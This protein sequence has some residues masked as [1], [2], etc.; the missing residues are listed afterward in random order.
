ME[1]VNM[2]EYARCTLCPRLCG[3]RR[4]EGVYGACHAGAAPRV[5]H[6]RLH[7]WEEPCLSG[8]RGSGTVF[9]SGCPLSCVYCQNH[10]ISR[11]YIGA[12]YSVDELA[13]LFLSLESQGAHNVNLVTATHYLPHVLL[14]IEGARE[15]G[16]SVPVVYNTSG[17]ERVESIRRLAA[18]A[19]VF[20]TDVRYTSA[21]TAA[22]YSAA[23]DYPRAS[24]DALTEMVRVTGAPHFDGEG[25]MTRGVIVRILLLPGHLIEAKRIL[26]NVYSAFGD[27]VYISLMS[28]YTPTEEAARRDPVLA[29]TVTPYEYKSLVD[30]ARTLGVT[31]AFTQEGSAAQE[32]FIPDFFGKKT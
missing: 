9:F 30:Y 16:L 12:E 11:S 18:H 32:S 5:A 29:R 7:M 20:L 31:H 22:A 19:D 21:L 8:T 6:V 4:T 28:Q 13:S 3:A 15:R 23:P 1:C 14:A 24:M 26:K 2:E 17:Y 27:D 10:E 25:M